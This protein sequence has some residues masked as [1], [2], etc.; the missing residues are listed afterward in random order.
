[1]IGMTDNK[2]KESEKRRTRKILLVLA[3]IGLGF[4]FAMTKYLLMDF[5]LSPESDFYFVYF[6]PVFILLLGAG[7][8]L[9]WDEITKAFPGLKKK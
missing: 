4:V 7:L 2:V 1:M 6:V 3:I 9:Y 8:W 5:G